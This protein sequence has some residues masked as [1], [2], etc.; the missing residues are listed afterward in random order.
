MRGEFFDAIVNATPVGMHP[1]VA[2][3]PL[4]AGEINCRLVFDTIYRPR[5]QNFCNLRPA[6]HPNGFWR[7]H[8]RGARRS[9]VGDLDRAAC[10]GR[11][12]AACRGAHVGS[13]RKGKPP[14]AESAKRAR[15]SDD[16]TRF[17]GIQPAG[18]AGNLVPVYE[19]YTADLLTPVGAYLRLA[20]NA[21]YSFLLESVEGGENI[22]RYTFT[23]ANPNEVFRARGRNC[24]LETGGKRVQFE[25][26]PVEKLRRLMKRY[27]PVRVPGLPPLT[28]GAIGYFAYDMVRLI[29]KIPAAGRDDVGLD[30][31]VMMFYLGLVVFDHVRHRVWIIR[32]VFTDGKGSLRAKV[33]RRGA[34]NPAHAKNA[35]PAVAARSGAACRWPV[36]RGIQHDQSAI[37]GRRAQSEELYP[38]GATFFRWSPASAF[39]RRLRPIHLR[40]IARCVS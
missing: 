24:S 9:A 32:N 11:R 13:G 33:R 22:A 19:T 12:D 29:E 30:D 23:G 7:G 39:R 34:R 27:H 38:R 17:Q 10:A 16:P 5:R 1:H 21:K 15:A 14:E 6:W 40:F 26:D 25:D 36:A 37:R 28:G 31:C 8:V 20:H 2:D 3:S 4:D 35:R 18:E